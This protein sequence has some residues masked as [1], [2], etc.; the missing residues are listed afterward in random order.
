MDRISLKSNNLAGW[1]V[2][3]LFFLGVMAFARVM[4]GK[5]LPYFSFEKAVNFLGTKQDS[6]L[7][8]PV[9]RAAFYV[10]ISTAIIVM[11]VGAGQFF[12]FL[13]RKKPAVHRLLGKVYVLGILFFAAPSGMVLA[14]FANGGL[15]SRVGFSLQCLVWFALTAAAW[16]EIRRR[17]WLNH[18]HFMMRSYAVT[19]AAMSLRTESYWM[20]YSLGTKPIETYVTVTWLSWVGNLVVVECMIYLGL[21]RLLVSRSSASIPNPT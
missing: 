8:N 2:G 4:L 19:L 16:R 3:G 20:L 1:L 14:K 12:P 5:T 15:P 21:G 6:V 11:V 13:L 17:R 10:H 7:E 18:T 9:F